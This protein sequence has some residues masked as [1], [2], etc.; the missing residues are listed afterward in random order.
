VEVTNHY[1]STI[2]WTQIKSQI[3]RCANC[4]NS[5][6]TLNDTIKHDG[7]LNG[8]TNCSYQFDFGDDP[9]K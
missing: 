8:L 7:G 3:N 1:L 4:L 2:T 5:T 6:H 9:I